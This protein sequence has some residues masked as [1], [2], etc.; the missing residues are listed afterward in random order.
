MT[1]NRLEWAQWMASKGIT[2]FIVDANSKR[3]LGG[4]SWYVRNT[5]DPQQIADWFDMTPN[6]N[7]GLHL[8]EQYV[9]IDLD[10]KP[11]G[12]NGIEA[13]EEICRENGVE[14]FLLEFN[15]L[16]V[17]TPSGG[18]HLYFKTPEPCANKNT[19]PDGIDVRGAVG[20][21]VGPG[22]QNTQGTWEIIDPN[23]PIMDIPDFLLAYLVAPGIK[24]PNHE[25]PLIE[26]DMEESIQQ[27]MDW[28]KNA[29]PAIAGENGDDHTYDICCMLRDFGISETEALRVLNESGWNERC[30]PAW[31]DGELEVKIRNSYS[32]GQNR[33]GIKAET[34][35]VQ[36]LT[37]IRASRAPIT[38]EQV[39]AMFRPKQ[40]LR[41]QTITVDGDVVRVVDWE[42]DQGIPLDVGP[43]RPVADTSDHE[44]HWLNA[45]EIA[46]D[47]FPPND[48]LFGTYALVGHV[49]PLL[50]P[51][52]IG[53]TTIGLHICAATASGA[54]LWGFETRKMPVVMLLYEDA[55]S[56][57]QAR[58]RAIC[59]DLGVELKDLDI[60]VLHVEREEEDTALAYVDDHGGVTLTEFHGALEA[61][62]SE[63]GEPCLLLADTLME[64]VPFNENQKASTSGAL[65]RVL[66]GLCRRYDTTIITTRHPSRR[67]IK[68]GTFNPGDTANEGD[69]RMTLIVES[70]GANRLELRHGKFNFGPKARPIRLK[71]VGNVLTL[72]TDAKKLREAG[73]LSDEAL[74]V[75]GQIEDARENN[76]TVSL[77]SGGSHLNSKRIAEA[78]TKDDTNDF[79]LKTGQVRGHILNL[80]KEGYLHMFGGVRGGKN[81]KPA[82]I[83]VG[84]APDPDRYNKS[85]YLQMFNGIMRDYDADIPHRDHHMAHD[86]VW[87]IFYSIQRDIK[88]EK[89]R[90]KDMGYET[91]RIRIREVMAWLKSAAT[92]DLVE[93][94]RGNDD[95]TL[96]FHKK[97]ANEGGV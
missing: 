4:N 83:E 95:G 7:Y 63:I 51:P 70:E 42:R 73:E 15:T 44:Y 64:T 56:V 10:W 62:L 57:T 25:V 45:K 30:E 32:F 78:I 96:S 35:R 68:D 91:E 12:V 55:M 29:K 5:M 43:T 94:A 17:N 6:C 34:Y 69:V 85:T 3:P 18:Y 40:R 90:K 60:H 52:D 53:K 97:E 58:L 1:R 37:E 89:K 26:L 65:K 46:A 74:L 9:V 2:A 22:S 39:V 8:G 72:D 13:F 21:V 27:A 33:P 41:D 80:V 88:D 86:I 76:F 61:K 36:R 59:E 19:F 11:G 67:A 81:Y 31:D 14:D 54:E 75:L 71:R 87:R 66:R 38:N 82:T 16:M 50:G 24:D 93:Y 49:T 28:L 23:M 20:Y 48:Y 47:E 84:P 92:T 77:T 79:N